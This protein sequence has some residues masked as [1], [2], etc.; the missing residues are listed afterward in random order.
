MSGVVGG[1]APEPRSR[2]GR[3]EKNSPARLPGQAH[4][5]GRAGLCGVLCTDTKGGSGTNPRLACEGAWGASE[6]IGRFAMIVFA[7]PIALA[8]RMREVAVV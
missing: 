2:V 7:T 6:S 5:K 8:M 4:G 3:L 1:V